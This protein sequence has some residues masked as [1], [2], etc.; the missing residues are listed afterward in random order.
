MGDFGDMVK[1]QIKPAL[2]QKATVKVDEFADYVRPNQALAT[3]ELD[4]N[5]FQHKRIWTISS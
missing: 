1:E 5:V 2:E 3:N 4:I